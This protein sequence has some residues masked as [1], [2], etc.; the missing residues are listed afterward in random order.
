MQIIKYV[1]IDDVRVEIDL[2][3]ADI[4]DALSGDTEYKHTISA[5]LNNIAQFLKAITD[6]QIKEFNEDQ[7]KAIFKFFSEQIER[8]KP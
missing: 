8:W 2:N 3:A 1:D 5:G 4:A 6:D 7:K